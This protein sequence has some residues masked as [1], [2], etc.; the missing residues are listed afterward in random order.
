MALIGS[1]AAR[2]AKSILAASTCCEALRLRA[3]RIICVCMHLRE[4]ASPKSQVRE[5][6]ARTALSR[7][8]P[9]LTKAKTYED[10]RAIEAT[11]C[12]TWRSSRRQPPAAQRGRK[13]TTTVSIWPSSPSAAGAHGDVERT[14]IEVVDGLVY[15]TSDGAYANGPLPIE[16][17]DYAPVQKFS[18]WP[19]R[20]GAGRLR[21]QSALSPRLGKRGA[22]KKRSNIKMRKLTTA[23]IGRSGEL[24]VQYRL[25]KH[26]IES[27][28]MT[29]D[30]GI[31]LVA[32][33]PLEKRAVTIQVKSNKQAKAVGGKG[34]KALNW[35]HL[36]ISPA[37]MVALV[38]LENDRVWLFRHAELREYAQQHSTGRMQFYLY[39]DAAYKPKRAK[40]HIGD[41]SAFEIDK[42]VE[43]LFGVAALETS[44]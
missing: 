5:H 37:E 41:F 40:T 17:T 23:Q 16:M 22:Y 31:D 13:M 26:G 33:A 30:S 43:E 15:T 7:A 19:S 3:F 28:P 29:T 44:N 24:L 21:L 18:L 34:Q 38:D 8:C 2:V 39:V 36:E 4:C 12:D 11:C 6:I 14:I 10:S 25:L 42:R 27:A 32:Y 1:D 35:F 9:R 20:V